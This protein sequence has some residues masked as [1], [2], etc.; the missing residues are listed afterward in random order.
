MIS[1]ERCAD[2]ISDVPLSVGQ[3]RLYLVLH[4]SLGRVVTYDTIDEAVSSDHAEPITAAARVS[5][6]KLLRRRLKS[7][8]HPARIDCIYGLGYRMTM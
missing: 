1:D 3:A 2:L 4:D 5:R 7:L 8:C 6:V